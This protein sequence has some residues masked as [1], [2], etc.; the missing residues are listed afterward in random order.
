ML[1]AGVLKI[2][3]S[4]K[5]VGGYAFGNLLIPVS[6]LSFFSLFIESYYSLQFGCIN[7]V[8]PIQSPLSLVLLL[9][10]LF[11]SSYCRWKYTR[12]FYHY[13]SVGWD[14]NDHFLNFD[15][16]SVIWGWWPGEGKG[17]SQAF[18]NIELPSE[19]RV[20]KSRG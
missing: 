6:L 19:I 2:S 20:V 12:G 9:A 16:Y 8:L 13:F 4:T 5:M 7:E 17:N 11:N 1:E 15:S 10:L 18:V 3:W 14:E